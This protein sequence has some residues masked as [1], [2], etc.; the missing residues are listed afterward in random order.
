MSHAEHRNHKLDWQGRKIEIV[1]QPRSFAGTAHL[2]VRA[3][4]ARSLPITETGYR[5][6]FPHAADVEHMGGPVAYVTAWLD[7]Y[8]ETKAWRRAARDGVQLGLF[9]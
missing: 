1:Y 4:H 8:A 5:S 2:Q 6:H 9:Q 3:R 7:S